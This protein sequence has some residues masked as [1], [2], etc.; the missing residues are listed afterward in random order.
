MVTAWSNYKA[1]LAKQAAGRTRQPKAEQSLDD[2]L[3]LLSKT[4]GKLRG[5]DT[6]AWTKDEKNAF[7]QILQNLYESIQAILNPPEASNL[8]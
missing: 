5:L 8:A 1:K 6:S 7:N 4:A 3:G 2:V